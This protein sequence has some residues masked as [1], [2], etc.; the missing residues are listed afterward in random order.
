MS[1]SFGELVTHRPSSVFQSLMTLSE[2]SVHNQNLLE[3]RMLGAGQRTRQCDTRGPGFS[4]LEIDGT[5]SA[6]GC[7]LINRH[8]MASSEPKISCE[9]R[10]IEPDC[11][12]A[13]TSKFCL[14]WF[15][16][17]L[18]SSQLAFGCHFRIP[19]LTWSGSSASESCISLSLWT[20]HA[21]FLSQGCER[22]SWVL[23]SSQG[24]ASRTLG[25]SCR[26][27]VGCRML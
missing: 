5:S 26:T 21:S 15:C 19:S 17:D 6:L 9:H 22:M 3:F 23:H 4:P 1:N 7:M 14:F 20:V 24:Y 18:W 2:C 27:Q 16:T 13:K 11:S 10:A 8:P 12:S 25:R